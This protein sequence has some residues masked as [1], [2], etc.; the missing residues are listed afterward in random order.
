MIETINVA[1]RIPIPKFL[2]W[3]FFVA[4]ILVQ[5]VLFASPDSSAVLPQI[6]KNIKKI[7]ESVLKGIVA[8][9]YRRE[10]LLEQLP[11]TALELPQIYLPENVAHPRLISETQLFRAQQNLI[12]SPFSNW[13]WLLK[14]QTEPYLQDFFRPEPFLLRQAEDMKSLA[15]LYRITGEKR[16]LSALER[17]LAALPEPPEIV[18]FEGGKNSVGWGDYLE[19]AQSA[20]PVA[21]ALDLVCNDLSD[22]IRNDA[23]E[24][25]AQISRQLMDAVLLAGNN[26]HT[27]VMAIALL[28]IAI[29][30]DHP[31]N[32]IRND[33]QSMWQ[34]GLKFLSRSLGIIAPDGGYAEGVYYGNFICSHL[35][36]FSVYFENVTGI[37]L[38]R[39]PYLERLVNWLLANNKGSGQYS[40]FDDAYQ[41]RFFYLP[42]I[43]PQS[44]LAG[45]W[46]AH[47]LAEPPLVSAERNV[48]EA[49]AIYDGSDQI[50]P[51]YGSPSRFFVESGE[52]IFRDRA[53]QPQFF[54]A[55]LSEHEQWFASRHE[56]IDPMSVEISAFGEDFIVDAGY[57]NATSDPNRP[58]FLSGRSS[59][60]I[61]V[62][63]MGTYENPIFGDPIASKIEH[64][65]QT[66]TVA[67][68]KFSHSI[69]DVQLMRSAFF[70]GND[71]LLVIDEFDAQQP[72]DI[73]LNFNHPGKLRQLHPNLL[74][75]VQPTA[76]MKLL[77]LTSE[78]ESPQIVQD[79]GLF[80]PK[81]K[82]VPVN[83][84][85]IG[86][87]DVRNGLFL[88]V[89]LPES[90]QASEVQLSP[91]AIKNGVRGYRIATAADEI[92]TE[93]AVGN[94]EL[95]AAPN[96]Q[97][98][99]RAVWVQMTADGQISGVMI[100]TGTFF[101]SDEFELRFE[102]P[103]TLMLSRTAFGWQGF[104]DAPPV[105]F[106]MEISG[107]FQGAF[108]LQR[109]EVVPFYSDRGTTKLLLN[110]SGPLE[111]GANFHPVELPEPF[112][113]SP[114]LLGWLARQPN[115]RE[116]YR[117]WPDYYQI[118]HQNQ[119]MQE[120]RS[121]VA[122]A[123]HRFSD[124]QFGDPYAIDYT[125]FAIYGIMQ[126]SYNRN[127]PSAFYVKIPHR[128]QFA[129]D[130]G[131]YRW[132]IVENGRFSLD[133]LEIHHFHAD[134]ADAAGNRF[135]YRRAA[136]FAG[137]S[138]NYLNLELSDRYE[139][140]YMNAGLV[141][142]ENQQF[143][144]KIGF[145]RSF[146]RFGQR[147]SQKDRYQY[148]DGKYQNWL[149]TFSHQN[150]A[151]SKRQTLDL[152]GFGQRYAVAM[153]GDWQEK[154]QHY[155]GN[156]LFYPHSKIKM[157]QFF[158]IEKQSVWH[159][160]QWLGDVHF[161]Q[162]TASVRFALANRNQRFS[163]SLTTRFQH[164]NNQIWFNFRS[165]SLKINKNGVAA[166][167]WSH[168]SP[169][170]WQKE[171]Q[172]R[173]GFLPLENKFGTEIQQSWQVNLDQ[174][175]S[176]YPVF[177][178]AFE[179]DQPLNAIGSGFGFRGQH[180]FF[181]QV[182]INLSNEKTAF[183]YNLSI[184]VASRNGNPLFNLWLQI[185]QMGS[186]LIRNEIRLVPLW[187]GVQPGVYFS[188]QRGIGS[189]LEAAVQLYF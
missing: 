124:E 18:N 40:A 185:W 169:A 65:F 109:R 95:M 1:F 184:D 35:A 87:R 142:Q 34:T 76:R 58:W 27:T 45:Q 162:K 10:N 88:T 71:M 144:G 148:V 116:V 121:G 153:A 85:Q 104:L 13:F 178:S 3:H 122:T 96:W 7:P 97:T 46:R 189:R 151:G 146:V 21:V 111:I 5:P 37:D 120:F 118:T 79:F 11:L 32:F 99:A 164:K 66:E 130:A 17:L 98:D 53:V 165:E 138:S 26:N 150:D 161:R 134:V 188:Y 131:N 152:N 160:R 140:G 82:G 181:S 80:T 132:K 91:L 141:G 61:L 105:N 69:G 31:E 182:M 186:Q 128:Y 149:A 77:T 72:H 179:H 106:E 62:D 143:F 163:E 83:N 101:S 126:Q 51:E 22:E 133:D 54:A 52:V 147:T 36:A 145:E 127:S 12:R 100:N 73:R 172:L 171:T 20:I 38:F 94:G 29:V 4:L 168:Q 129:D 136:E 107:I 30:V 47:F 108:Q 114:D 74:E 139:F 183:S 68:A 93:V 92:S 157:G 9:G 177:A 86:Q 103:V 48:V 33:R 78:I 19:S 155:V 175:L 174:H 70:P 44:R 42:L 90:G 57:G 167:R 50:L 56:H 119:L 117:Y 49:L 64:A 135:T 67:G 180:R 28:T 41:T 166:I 89:M 102:V 15:F 137:H 25:L 110:G 158:Q 115:S 23:F 159:I 60:G 24:K 154:E 113:R 84:L 59:N 63:G 173:Y 170:N 14:M 39:H 75:I 2:R 176:V 187:S 43:I 81:S 156:F 125:A 6:T 16:Y 123:I 8:A 112:R 55:F